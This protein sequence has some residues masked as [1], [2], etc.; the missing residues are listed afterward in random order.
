MTA[1]SCQRA[2]E[3]FP[4]RITSG[5][6]P[7]AAQRP[8]VGAISLMRMDDWSLYALVILEKRIPRR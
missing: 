2:M 4:R 8:C 3:L 1:T 5:D 6:K 7:Q